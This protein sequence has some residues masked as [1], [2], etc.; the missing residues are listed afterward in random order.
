VYV[1]AHNGDILMVVNNIHSCTE[2]T[3]N[4]ETN[5]SGNVDIS[6]CSNDDTP[7]HLKSSQYGGLEVRDETDNNLLPIEDKLG[8]EVLWAT[9]KTFD[10]FSTQHNRNIND[11]VTISIINYSGTGAFYSNDDGVLLYGTN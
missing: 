11:S 3:V 4:A 2:T 1:D 5:Y 8:A 9:Q 7:T 10:Y 6:V